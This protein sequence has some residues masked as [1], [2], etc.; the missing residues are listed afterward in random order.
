MPND[1]TVPVYNFISTFLKSTDMVKKLFA[2]QPELYR[3]IT[4]ISFM[5]H[6]LYRVSQ[7]EQNSFHLLL[8]RL[9]H[10][11]FSFEKKTLRSL[12]V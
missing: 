7:L 5:P 12:L 9:F 8:F 2:E 11:V 4:V 1:Y 10:F 6:V 3:H